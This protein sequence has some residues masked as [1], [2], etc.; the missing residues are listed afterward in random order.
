MTSVADAPT[1]RP[2]DAANDMAPPRGI[3]VKLRWKMLAAFTGAFTIVFVFL[4][5]WVF[6][7]TTETAQKRLETQLEGSA[8]GGAATIN[9]PGFVELITTVP[10]IPDA[11]NPTGLGYPTS[12]LY[13]ANAEELYHINQI[14]PEANP[15]SYFQDPADGKLYFAASAGF[16]VSPPIGVTYKVP[17]DSI[18]N[19]ETY[20]LMVEGLSTTT[21]QEPYTDDYGSWISS[22]TPILDDD[23]KPVGAL[24]VDY[25]MT[26][27]AQVQSDVQR[28]LY[29]VLG[30]SYVVLLALVLILSTSLTR[31]LNR[32][33]A[34]T[35]RIAAGEYDLDVRSMV[36]TRFPDEMYTLAES[37]TS[38]AAKVAARER[39]LTQEVQR[40]K[41]E[42][43]HARREEA[44]KQITES[45]SFAELARKAAEMR[46]RN[47]GED[48]PS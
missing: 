22:Y 46:R 38:M 2:A 25:P 18:V 24:G 29:P 34:A 4:A 26:Y 31:P 3:R 37:F 45:D 6:Q 33:T 9:A 28:R 44:V 32:L 35:K 41:V 42:I 7:Y 12:P 30:V 23:G 36:H 20:A 43:D 40:L 15:Y 10:A 16:M 5:I 39:S 14:V 48:Q 1:V 13:K 17:V 19:A 8:V 47:R 21:A 11:S 27:V